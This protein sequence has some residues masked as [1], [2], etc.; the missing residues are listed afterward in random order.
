MLDL[1]RRGG[2]RQVLAH[3]PVAQGPS[4]PRLIPEEKRDKD[5]QNRNEENENVASLEF[6]IS[7]FEF[8]FL[9]LPLSLKSLSQC[10]CFW[11]Q[12]EQ[13]TVLFPGGPSPVPRHYL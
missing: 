6:R 11:R 13:Y 5:H 4:E 9:W 8:Q 2:V 1:V 10:S 7:S 3:L 12:D